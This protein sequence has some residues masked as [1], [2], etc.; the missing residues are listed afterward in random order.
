MP[1]QALIYG[2][3]TVAAGCLVAGSAAVQWRASGLASFLVCL[4]LAALA[5]TFKVRVPGLTGTISPAFVFVLVAAGQLGWSETVAIGAVSALIQALWRAQT[6]PR[7][8]QLFFNVAT[9]TIAA[10][11][12]HGVAHGLLAV[13]DGSAAPL[14]LAVAGLVLFVTNTLMVSTILCLIKGTP[15]LLAWRALQIWSVPYYLAGGVTRAV[16]RR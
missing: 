15:V 1:R 13:H 14:F 2:W 5:S 7:L 10:G 4:A 11:L 6:R 9:V 3:A 8:L 16:A 12:A